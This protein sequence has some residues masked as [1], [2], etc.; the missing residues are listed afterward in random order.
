MDNTI[1]TLYTPRIAADQRPQ[2]A[3]RTKGG[4]FLDLAQRLQGPSSPLDG[5]P[6]LTADLTTRGSLRTDQTAAAEPPSLEEMLRAKYPRLSYHVFDA[7]SGYWRTRN[8]YPHYLLYQQD[9]DTEAIENWQPAGP[10]PFY[11]SVDG[12][13]MAS[14]EIHALSA[15]PPGSKAVVIHPAVQARMEEDPAYA[16]EIMERIDTYF[17]FDVARNEAILPG[18][19]VGMNQAIAIGEDGSIVNVQAS[20]SGGGR[21]TRSGDTEEDALS[22]W[23]LRMARHAYFMEL[24]IQGQRE[25]ALLPSAH[26]S[27][28][29]AKAQ[30]AQLLRSGNLIDLLGDTIAGVS[31]ESVLD[32]T[33]EQVWGAGA[34]PL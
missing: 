13:F 5:D 21:I 29:A 12:K 22:W 32:L 34:L 6:A 16:R 17:A 30:L 23:D 20:S 3:R 8:D 19:T 11:G 2:G 14:K 4:S 33:V 24:L 15:I 31:T 26:V 18:S 1:S 27:S 7:S 28:G 10:N 25:D 9:I